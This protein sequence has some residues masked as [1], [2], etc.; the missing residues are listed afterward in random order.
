MATEKL[1]N[2]SILTQKEVA[3]MLKVSVKSV[4]N[5]RKRGLPFYKRGST[6]RFKEQEVLEWFKGLEGAY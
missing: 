6:V 4:Y 5:W 1:E 2:N 3:D